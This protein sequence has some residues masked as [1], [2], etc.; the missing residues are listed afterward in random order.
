ML[1]TREKL[2]DLREKLDG[3]L[4]VGDGALGTLLADRGIDRPY[5]KANLTHANTARAIHEEA[6]EAQIRAK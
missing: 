4:L 5:Y 2:L 1:D 3:C 6:Q